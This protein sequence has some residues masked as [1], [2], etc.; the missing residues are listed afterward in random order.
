MPATLRSAARAL[1]DNP[2]LL[3]V[4][5]TLF[6]AG[7]VI[8][9]QLARGEVTPMQ[10]VLLRWVVVALILWPIFGGQVIAHWA[11]A[12]ARI[13]RIVL[14]AFIGFTGFNTMFYIASLY[15]GAVNIGILQGSMP[16]F[17]LLGAF[18]AHGTR[19]TGVQAVGVAVTMLG[20]ALVA[21][22]GRPWDILGLQWNPG[23]LIMLSACALYAAYAVMLQGRP[24]IPGPVF[25]TLLT[26]VAMVTAIPMAVAEAAFVDDYRLP[27]VT[28][29]LVTLY[30]ALFPS[31]LAQIFFLRGVDLIG[32]GRA[33][34]YT[35]LVPVFAAVMAVFL[36][37]ESF[38]LYHGVAL[39]LVLGGIALAQRRP[40]S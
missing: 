22:L 27:T 13:G 40:R 18:L 29:W 35:N 15:T 33:G 8:A 17:V 3:L 25:F 2:A 10:L 9:G 38:A 24:D 7:N 6:W 31:C 21:T 20:V 36:L 11:T 28:G 1:Y 14:M 39:V 32:P 37:R 19:V 16:G 5:T 12:R 34:V 4:L 26:V 23:D 30:I